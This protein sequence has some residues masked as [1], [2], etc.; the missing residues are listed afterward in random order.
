MGHDESLLGE[1]RP[2]G[3]YQIL[4]DGEDCKVK[5]I[6]VNPG[7]RLSLQ[8]HKHRQE[9]WYVVAGQGSVQLDHSEHSVQVDSRVF[10]AR[11]QKHRVKN[12]GTV[13]LVFIEIQTGTYFGEDDITRYEDDY[14]RD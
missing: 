6:T 11:E 5:R 3:G 14:G 2:W 9:D 10:I 12:T 7:Q 1:S 8:S 4:Y 13:D